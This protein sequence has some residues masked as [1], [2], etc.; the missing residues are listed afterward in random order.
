MTPP[1]WSFPA[2]YEVQLSKQFSF[3]LYLTFLALALLPSTQLPCLNETYFLV[4]MKKVAALA[5]VKVFD[6]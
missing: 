6:P 2:G 4:T 5:F 1:L 3:G